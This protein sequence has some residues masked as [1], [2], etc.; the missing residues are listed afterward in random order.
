MKNKFHQMI[1]KLLG[2]QKTPKTV[3]LP[4]SKQNNS[5]SKKEKPHPI[6][7]SL[8]YKTKKKLQN[9]YEKYMYA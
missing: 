3:Y 8:S 7:V 4:E 2:K 1:N 5:F 6:R 9:M